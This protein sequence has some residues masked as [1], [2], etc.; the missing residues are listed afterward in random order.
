MQYNN[1][2]FISE[3]IQ[4]PLRLIVISSTS[5]CR[6][7]INGLA[8]NCSALMIAYFRSVDLPSRGSADHHE[9][10]LQPG[11]VWPDLWRAPA[12]S[13]RHLPRGEFPRC[14]YCCNANKICLH[15]WFMIPRIVSI[16][17][18][19]TLS[20]IAMVSDDEWYWK[21]RLC[22]ARVRPDRR[23]VRLQLLTL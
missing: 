20:C 16:L 13:W 21:W 17:N 11:A 2:R 3:N 15:S 5:N 12:A 22:E 6:F 1:I 4:R 7:N 18:K 19:W 14:F 8:S 10:S 23:R 9:Q